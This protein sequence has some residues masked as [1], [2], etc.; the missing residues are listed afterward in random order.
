[1]LRSFQ[2]CIIKRNEKCLDILKRTFSV[3][4]EISIADKERK[5]AIFGGSSFLAR[6]ICCEL[7]SNDVTTYIGNRGDEFEMRYL[8]TSYDLGRLKFEFY[9]PR[10]VNS[11]RAVISDADIVINL[12]AKGYDTKA[13]APSEKFP[14]LKLK[15]NYSVEDANVEIPKLIAQ[16]CTEMQVD[17][18]IHF[19]CMSASPESKSEFARAK[20]KGECAVKEAYP[21]ATI[22]KPTHVFG[23]QDRF[24]NYFAIAARL[25]PFIPFV[26]DGGAL[27]QPV[28]CGDVAKL[29]SKI[30]KLPDKYEGK[31]IHCFGDKDFS[32]KELASFVY[33]ITGQNPTIL[34]LPKNLVKTFAKLTKFQ[35]PPLLTPDSVELWSEDCIPPLSSDEY[36]KQTE[37]LTLDNFQIQPT[38]IEKIAFNYLH[39]FRTGGHFARAEG[40]QGD[41]YIPSPKIKKT[42]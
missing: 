14:Y 13:L 40:Y 37:I 16:L 38:P 11:M 1:M 6:Y 23:P 15:T 42:L 34:D 31:T 21:W 41:E 36:K 25:F 39:R 10:D 28:Y 18:L 20:F 3:S 35:S 4:K 7:G 33:D 30:V 8:K 19:S 27:T 9:S 12:I 5:V 24:L 22:I 2:K 32:Y 29:V 26:E 17:H